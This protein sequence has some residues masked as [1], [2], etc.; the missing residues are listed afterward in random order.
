M[1]VKK[2]T[3]LSFSLYGGEILGIAGVAGSGQKELCE[4]VAG[5]QKASSGSVKFM[6]EE[7][8]GLS[9]RD[10]TA[11]HISMSFIPEDRLGMGLVAGMDIVD[12]MLLK[13][14]Q[15]TKGPF[16]DRSAGRRIAQEV[17]ETF[18]IATPSVNT[19][20][21]SSPAANIQKVLLG[22]EV[23]LNPSLLIT[24]YPVRGAGH[25]RVVSDLRHPQRAKA[26]GRCRAVHRRGPRRAALPVRP[27]DGAARGKGDGHRGPE[28]DKPRGSRLMMLG[29]APQGG[30][31]NG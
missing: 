3:D 22:R 23:R 18:A 31:A 12:N 8:L 5:L 26:A 1:R 27:P 6:G 20:S 11:R 16:V 9:P 21:R 17:V 24:A 2:L 29:H 30:K 10:I 28:A 15:D 7:I 25:R 4:I 13:S 19:L 14:Y